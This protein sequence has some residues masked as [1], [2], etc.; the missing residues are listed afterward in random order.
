MKRVRGAAVGLV[1]LCALL[2]VGAC[3]GRAELAAPSSEGGPGDDGALPASDGGVILDD[4]GNPLDT[5]VGRD[6]SALDSA[7]PSLD[8]GHDSAIPFDSAIPLDSAVPPDSATIDVVHPLDTGTGCQAGFHLCAGVCV[9]D[10]APATCGTS[11][12]PCPAPANGLASCDGTSCSVSCDPGYVACS[13]GCCGCGDVQSDPNNCGAC[14]HS[15]GGQTCVGGVCG[16][17]IV[18]S[19]QANAYAIAADDANVYWTTTGAASSVV[20]AP[21]AGGGATVLWQSA[22]DYPAALALVSGEVYWTNEIQAGGVSRV[23]IGGGGAIPVTPAVDYPYA[24]TASGGTLFF[25]TAPYTSQYGDVLSVPVGGGTVT[26][27]AGQQSMGQASSIA[28]GGNRVYWNTYSD[29][30][31]A[32]LG[33]GTPTTFAAQQYP[34]AVAADANNVYWASQLGGGAV[35]RQSVMGGTPTTIAQNQYY[36]D[37]VLVDGPNLYWTTGQ[38]GTGTVMKVPVTGGTPVTL[39]ANQA[40]PAGLASNST[41]LFWVDFGDGTIRSVPK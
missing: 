33:G 10:T 18:A 31:A 2:A 8:A 21:I 9:D 24:L 14:G 12:T 40:Y 20:Q 41:L 23:P 15:C 37:A 22:N 16:S 28:V 29:V 30:M 36:P 1:P 32:P 19:H 6:G 26:T 3:G 5:G 27:V 7:L 11:C 4:A 13:T 35:V 39:A 38:G 17:V 34:V 25:T